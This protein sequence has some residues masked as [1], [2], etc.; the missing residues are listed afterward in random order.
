MTVR[1][2]NLSVRVVLRFNNRVFLQRVTEN[3][4]DSLT[5]R[6]TL[7]SGHRGIMSR[8]AILLK[9]KDAMSLA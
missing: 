5:I 1:K 8:S 2:K 4:A 7:T 9:R 6:A 3:H